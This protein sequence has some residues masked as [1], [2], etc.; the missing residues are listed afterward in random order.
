MADIIVRNNGGRELARREW[1]PSS[2]MRELLR[3]DPFREMMPNLATPE[4]TFNPAFEIK[5][6]KEGYSFK[7]DLPGVAEK[8]LE[9]TRSGTRLTIAGKRE[10]A[11]EDQKETYYACERAYGSFTRTFTLPDGIDGEHVHAELK[12]GVLSVFVPK[13]PEA[14]PQRITIKPEVKKS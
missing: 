1:D 4:L 3:W 7:A 14:K 9:V 8:D 2:W 10:W 12:D 6:T 5:E 11:Y 13:L